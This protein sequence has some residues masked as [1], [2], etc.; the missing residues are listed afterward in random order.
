MYCTGSG[1]Q[2]IVE[3]KPLGIERF[4]R[5]D[6]YGI[7]T[8]DIWYDIESSAPSLNVRHTINNANETSSKRIL[9][10]EVLHVVGRTSR[11]PESIPDN[12]GTG[13]ACNTNL[14]Y[15]YCKLYFCTGT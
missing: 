7:R 8:Q 9:S 12:W 13:Y 10:S 2:L 1:T 6:P 4:F 11:T 14:Y 5:N 3:D 15:Q